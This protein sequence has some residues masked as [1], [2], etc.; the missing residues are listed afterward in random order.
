MRTLFTA[1]LF[2]LSSGL[3]AAQSGT[4]LGGEEPADTI[5][6]QPTVV[7]QDVVITGTRSLTDVRHLSQT[8]SVITR[9]S[10]EV[11]LQPSVIPLL[12]EQVPGMFTT[13]R[14]VMGYGVSTGSSGAISLRGLSGASGRLMVLIDG[15]PQY[16]GLMGHPIADSYQSFMVERVEVLRGPA[17]V[18]YGSNAMAGVVNIVTRGMHADGVKTDLHAGYGSYNTLETEV[19]N[20]IRRGRFSSVVSGSYNRTDGHRANLDFEQ[21]GGYVKLG[22]EL[23]HAWN[24]TANVDVTHFEASHPGTTD[25]PL[26]DAHQSITRGISQLSIENNYSRTSGALSLFYNWGNHY[27]DYGYA[28]DEDPLEYRF[29]SHDDMLGISAYQSMQLFTGNRLTVGIDFNYFGGMAYNRYVTGSRR[30]ESDKLV[31]KTQNEV[32]GYADFR[33]HLGHLLTLNIGLR[34][35]HHSELGTEW[36]PQAGLALHLPHD[37]EL[38]ASIA[39]GFRYPVIREMYMFTPQ[40]PDLEPESLW[41]YEVSL[42]QRLLDGRL[43]YGFNVFYIDAENLIASVARQGTTPLNMN[44]GEAENAGVEWQAAFRLNMNWS[45]DA[46][47]S[48]LHMETPIVAAPEHKLHLGAAYSHGRWSVTTGLQYVA[49][50]YT[51]TSPEVKEDFWLWNLR[52]QFRATRWLSLWARGENLLAQRY[53]IN[54]GYP[55]PKATFMAGLKINL[56]N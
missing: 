14:G 45:V 28:A 39:K 21:Y 35:D 4:R 10:I 11:S 40:N 3:Y 15:H 53:E 42:S 8:V 38:K 50:L 12:S 30:G 22:Y 1:L 43:N 16:M 32:A 49:G 29:D 5:V 6:R 25:E 33:Q 48:F 9:R 54:A 44:T 56:G 23:G 46:N 18:L 2:F 17:S 55:M 31:D 47:Y 51:S 26:T 24:L 41:N 13:A 34:V 52:A 7:T 27:I 36:I 19:G 37:V 20:R